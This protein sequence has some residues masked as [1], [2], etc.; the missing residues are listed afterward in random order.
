MISHPIPKEAE[1]F[2]HTFNVS[3]ET[4]ESLNTYA[5]LLTKWQRQIN[6]VGPSTIETLWT[7]HFADSLELAEHAPKEAKN[8]IDIG[9]GAGFPGMVIAT[10][11]QR[12]NIKVDLVESNGKKCAFLREVARTIKA[13]VTV[14]NRR[15]EAIDSLAIQEMCLDVV[16]ARALAP[17]DVLLKLAEKPFEKGA[18]GIFPRGQRVEGE[19]TACSKYWSIRSEIVDR[20]YDLPGQVLVV[21]EC[22]R[23]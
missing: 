20:N 4:I 6:L 10:C 19:L 16:T 7:R 9:T 2:S 8:W 14:H 5:E 18:M 22:K 1:E 13:P 23:R 12:Q 17:L 3:R 15:I 11:G 21:H